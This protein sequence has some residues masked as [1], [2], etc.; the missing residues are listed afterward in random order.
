MVIVMRSE[1]HVP[2]LSRLLSCAKPLQP[3]IGGD[4]QGKAT[5]LFVFLLRFQECDKLVILPA[6]L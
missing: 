5:A 2:H 1:D 3:T 6:L 4:E